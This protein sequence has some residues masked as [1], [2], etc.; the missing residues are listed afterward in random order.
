MLRLL[1]FAIVFPA[2][3]VFG[4]LVAANATG[5]SAIAVAAI[6]SSAVAIA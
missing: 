6:A 3:Q 2:G 1:T 4:P 5:T